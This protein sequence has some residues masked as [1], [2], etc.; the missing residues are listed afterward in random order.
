L[1]FYAYIYYLA[2]LDEPKQAATCFQK[3]LIKAFFMESSSS[4]GSAKT[5][6]QRSMFGF[7]ETFDN[8]L[9]EKQK[10]GKN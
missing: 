6:T 1:D 4:S 9:T 3:W 7:F 2:T 8:C 10:L 5:T